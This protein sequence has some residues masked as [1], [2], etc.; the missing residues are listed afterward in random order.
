MLNIFFDIKG[1]VH[2]EFGVAGETV[3]SAYYCVALRL[4]RENVRRL[5][6]NFVVWTKQMTHPLSI[7]A[8][9]L[10]KYVLN[11][12]EH[13]SYIDQ[14]Y[15]SSGV[16]VTVLARV[17]YK[18]K[19]REISVHPLYEMFIVAKTNLTALTLRHSD[20]REILWCFRRN[21]GQC[22]TRGFTFLQ[23]CRKR[24][25]KALFSDP[26]FFSDPWL[27]G[28]DEGKTF[29]EAE[30]ND[31]WAGLNGFRSNGGLELNMGLLNEKLASHFLG[32]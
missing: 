18:L 9:C 24:P 11:S 5:A 12:E 32:T 1:I 16:T 31:I 6:S 25:V 21:C 8:T 17:Y 23:N 2:K 30:C 15:P 29:V 27:A 20:G 28:V 4:S 19:S 7:N 13:F 14:N 26:C 10:L 3:N 22:L